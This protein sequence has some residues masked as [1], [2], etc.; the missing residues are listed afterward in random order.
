MGAKK[1]EEAM[2]EMARRKAETGR[3]NRAP[4]AGAGGSGGRN[5]VV[6][7]GKGMSSGVRTK[8]KHLQDFERMKAGHKKRKGR[9][10]SLS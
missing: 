7:A 4:A 9:E 8:N 3:R 10:N 2:R 6:A 5:K 1:H